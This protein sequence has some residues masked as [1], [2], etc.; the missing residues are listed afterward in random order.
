MAIYIIFKNGE[1]KGYLK[2]EKTARDA[3]SKWADILTEEM[4]NVGDSDAKMRVFRENTKNGIKIYKQ[5]LGDY[6]NGSVVLQYTIE[7]QYTPDFSIPNSD[8][9]V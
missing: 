8:V 4:K 2:D 3:V 9:C 7:Y 1:M 6:I 5:V